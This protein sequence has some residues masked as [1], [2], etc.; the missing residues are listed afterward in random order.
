MRNPPSPPTVRL[1]LRFE[2]P[3][4]DLLLAWM[5]RLVGRFGA[6]GELSADAHYLV[7]DV[8]AQHVD[9]VRQILVENARLAEPGIRKA[10]GTSSSGRS[11]AR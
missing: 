3:I 10:H 1:E 11:N 5:G 8:P 7:V 9:V 4:T 6:T 2:H